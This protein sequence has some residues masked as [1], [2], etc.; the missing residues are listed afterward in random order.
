MVETW[1]PPKDFVKGSDVFPYEDPWDGRML[2]TGP[3]GLGDHRSHLLKDS[4]P[5]GTNQYSRELT[6]DASYLWRPAPSTPFQKPRASFAGE[7]GYFAFDPPDRSTSRTGH[8]IFTSEFWRQ[9]EDVYTHRFQTPWYWHYSVGARPGLP[10]RDRP[11]GP[12]GYVIPDVAYWRARQ[13]Q[14]TARFDPNVQTQEAPQDRRT[15]SQLEDPHGAPE[16]E[17]TAAPTEDIPAADQTNNYPRPYTAPAST[18]SDSRSVHSGR[19]S[20]G[21][22]STNRGR[23]TFLKK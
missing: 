14:L 21:S 2:F 22:Y 8:Q 9:V 15:S 10:E 17:G 1:S 12:T 20:T 4:R 13:R 16:E 5:V 6:L 18:S 11:Y 7:I 3:S 23:F 19:S